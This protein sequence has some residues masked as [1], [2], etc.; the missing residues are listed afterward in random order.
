MIGAITGIY[1]ISRYLERLL[2]HYQILVVI[3]LI[4]EIIG[5]IIIFATFND[6]S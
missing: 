2:L 6:N 5:S 1:S 3:A 4:F